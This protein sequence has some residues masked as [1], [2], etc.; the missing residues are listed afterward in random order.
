MINWGLY[1]MYFSSMKIADAIQGAIQS[2]PPMA[3]LLQGG[4]FW[5]DLNS[6]GPGAENS[7]ISS[8]HA[9]SNR[10]ANKYYPPLKYRGLDGCGETVHFLSSLIKIV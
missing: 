4:E 10:G 6:Y 7:R 2:A 5:V 1:D 8:N 9:G 3:P